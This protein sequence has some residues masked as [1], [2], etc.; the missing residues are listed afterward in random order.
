MRPWDQDHLMV[1]RDTFS[2]I[3]CSLYVT[4]LH[5]LDLKLDHAAAMKTERNAV[6][7]RSSGLNTR[8]LLF[9]RGWLD[10]QRTVKCNVLRIDVTM[11]VQE[12]RRENRAQ[13]FSSALLALDW[14]YREASREHF[15]R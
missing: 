4:S 3:G 5:S 10:F 9:E 2:Q 7:S 12:T 6:L 11:M 8:D 1:H 13:L 14:N 15:S